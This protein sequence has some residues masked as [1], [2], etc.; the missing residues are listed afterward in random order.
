MKEQITPVKKNK[1]IKISFSQSD[2]EDLQSGE[3]FEWTFNTED[4]QA[5]DV[6]LFKGEQCEECGEDVEVLNDAD[7]GDGGTRQLCNTC[8]EAGQY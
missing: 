7:D 6:H 5:I 8:Y 4:G 3:T 1:S 2:L